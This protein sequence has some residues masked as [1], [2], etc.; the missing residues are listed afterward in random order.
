V[1]TTKKAAAREMPRPVLIRRGTAEAVLE[2]PQGTGAALLRTLGGGLT[3]Y[4]LV[5]LGLLWFP[6]QLGIAAWEFGTVT[7][8]FDVIPLV[9]VGAILTMWGVVHR[10]RVRSATVRA[11][12]VAFGIATLLILI[13]A[14]LY[15]RS[16]PMVL[17]EVPGEALAAV[18]RSIIETATAITVSS[19]TSALIAV[20]LWRSIRKGEG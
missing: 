9:G 1:E 14:A 6:L 18:R 8:T 11:A 7:E 5:R 15:M 20:R 16:V 2:E 13:F 12:A 19:V 3:L 17:T 10:P 4:E